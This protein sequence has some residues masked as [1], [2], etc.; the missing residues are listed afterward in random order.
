MLVLPV[1]HANTVVNPRTMVVEMVHTAITLT[2]VLCSD[3][4]HCLARVAHVVDG[5]V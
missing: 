2:T 4:S 3:W 1:S 5:I